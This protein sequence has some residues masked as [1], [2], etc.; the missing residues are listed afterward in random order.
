VLVKTPD[1]ATT[2]HRA[3]GCVSS[4]GGSPLRQEVGLGQALE[5]TQ[6]EIDWPRT[7]RTQTVT[8]VPL[9]SMIEIVQGKTG[10][11][12]LEFRRIT[13]GDIVAGDRTKI[14]D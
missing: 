9:D 11:R 14:V 4:F 5:I 8:D 6:I 2:F 13:Y 1:G 3:V 7:N 10:F 12:Q